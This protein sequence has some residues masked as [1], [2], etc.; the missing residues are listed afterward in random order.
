MIDDV[1][2]SVDFVYFTFYK[3]EMYSF[4][5]LFCRILPGHRWVA[6]G[7]LLLWGSGILTATA[8][9][10]LAGIRVNAVDCG[11]RGDGV[12][13]NTR[14]LQTAIDRLAAGGGGT[15][16]LSN[17]IYLSGALFLQPGVNLELAA[18]TVLR[19]STNILDYPKGRTRVE[20]QLIDWI[21][22]LLNADHCDHLRL[23]GQ[24][25]L[26]G[27]GEIFY[28]AFWA[29]RKRD[30]KVTNLAVE[31]P[32]LLLIQHS[33]DVQITGVHFKNSGFWNLHLYRC[34]DVLLENLHFTVL[35]NQRCP[36]TDGTDVDSC[37]RVT[38]RGCVYRV[39]DDCICLKGTK[40][41][42]AL[43]DTDS[44]PVEHIRV[45]NCIFERGGGVVTLGS[46]AT[47]VRD[48]VVTNCRV[49]GPI[50]VALL[51]L[52][53][54]T[55]QHYEDIHYSDI[56][57]DSTNRAILAIQPWKQFFD[58]KGQQPP[59]SIVRNITLSNIK[60]NYG[61]LANIQGN[62]NQTEISDIKLTN[63]N[64]HLQTEEYK[65]ASVKNLIFDQVTIN[66]K[67]VTLKN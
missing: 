42:F 2:A 56:T 17:G 59:K 4:A 51:K 5:K 45:E 31:R 19:G 64:V 40:G 26:D 46:E 27:N 11:A 7:L 30:P 50:N 18:D 8:Q 14:F 24:G 10:P 25:T 48:V 23:S 15:L 39:D 21:P 32:R 13:L 6:L 20:G 12:T 34:Q 54:D 16:V 52:R 37:Q 1:Q 3:S 33:Q 29:A 66:G 60:G 55:P 49:T 38:I 53:P 35:E 65:V 22:A 28:Q 58:L 47:L 36:S 44:P 9:T 43:D 61:T 67:P 62:A 57:L 63:I 41:P